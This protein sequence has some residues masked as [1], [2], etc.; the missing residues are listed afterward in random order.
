MG[1]YIGAASLATPFKIF[2]FILLKISMDKCA[3]AFYSSPQ[4]N[5]FNIIIMSSE[6][7][8]LCNALLVGTMIT[9][10]IT[11]KRENIRENSLV[12]PC[13]YKVNKGRPLL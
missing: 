8:V 11:R 10:K 4:F 1:V 3:C 6:Y 7:A 13:M 12:V 5:D 2:D 9:Y